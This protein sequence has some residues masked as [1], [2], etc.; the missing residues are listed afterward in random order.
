MDKDVPH[1]TV[2]KKSIW[3]SAGYTPSFTYCP[4][5]QGSIGWRPKED[6]CW[7]CNQKVIWK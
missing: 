5:C 7:R 6:R 3:Y 4:N 2:T 1:E